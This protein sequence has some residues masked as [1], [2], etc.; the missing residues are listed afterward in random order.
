M[1]NAIN[2]EIDLLAN[3]LKARGVDIKRSDIIE[4]MAIS[5]GYRNSHEMMAEAKKAETLDDNPKETPAKND[6]IIIDPQMTFLSTVMEIDATR[7]GTEYGGYFIT[8]DDD[9]EDRIKALTM[10]AKA[11]GISE[12]MDPT[13]SEED[14]LEELAMFFE[15]EMDTF[16]INPV[17]ISV[18]VS[19]LVTAIASGQGA[20]FML[21]HLGQLAKMIKENLAKEAARK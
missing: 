1:K 18:D 14:D 2:K 17:A 5:K 8:T 11:Y 19:E 4:S 20:E 10:C 15:G 21:N 9:L 12:M 3:A 7:D 13:L 6:V 16:D